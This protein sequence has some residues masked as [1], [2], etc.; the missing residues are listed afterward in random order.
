MGISFQKF[1]GPDFIQLTANIGEETMETDETPPDPPRL[2][3][4]RSKNEV[5]GRTWKES[6]R[7]AKTLIKEY[8]SSNPQWDAVNNLLSQPIDKHNLLEIFLVWVAQKQ[9]CSEL[10]QALKTKRVPTKFENIVKFHNLQIVSIEELANIHLIISKRRDIKRTNKRVEMLRRQNLLNGKV[11]QRQFK[12]QGLMNKLVDTLKQL[13]SG[14]MLIFVPPK[15]KAANLLVRHYHEEVTAHG[16]L[17]MVEIMIQKYWLVSKLTRVYKDVRQLCKNCK[18][19]DAKPCILP[20]GNFKS[21]R[22]D[23]RYPFEVTGTDFTGPLDKDERRKL[24]I[25]I[26]ADA[27]ARAVSL[28]VIPD[29]SYGSFLQAFEKFKFAHCAPAIIKSDNDKTFQTASVQEKLRTECYK[30]EWHFNPP[31]SSWWGAMYERLIRMIKEKIARCFNRQCFD[32]FLDFEAITYVEAIINNRLLYAGKDPISKRYT[33]IQLADFLHPN[34]QDD[35][36][37]EEMTNVF[38]KKREEAASSRQLDE[39]LRRQ[40]KFQKRVKLLFDECT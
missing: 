30:T 17:Q 26:L 2:V 3:P 12:T 32:S 27:Y 9:H 38:S 35:W 24:Y 13:E 37:D 36:F 14:D 40:I 6:C 20:E 19:V 8:V 33:M 15:S 16:S 29:K 28:F 23:T 18:F 25:C 31:Q 11:T 7:K 10:F 1:S 39:N 22:I 5:M 21:E 4:T 34:R